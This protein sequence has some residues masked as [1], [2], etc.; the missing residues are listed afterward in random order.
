[1]AEIHDGWKRDFDV[2][3]RIKELGIDLGAKEDAVREGDLRGAGSPRQDRAR[4]RKQDGV[5]GYWR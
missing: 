1:M 3:D 4:A 5:S 2:Y